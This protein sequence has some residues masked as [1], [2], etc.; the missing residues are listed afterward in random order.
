[1][2]NL[3]LTSALD[4]VYDTEGYH[5]RSHDKEPSDATITNGESSQMSQPSSAEGT[6]GPSRQS[7]LS[8]EALI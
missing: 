4:M 6:P 8:L 1:M 5:S 7:N 2:D 3:S